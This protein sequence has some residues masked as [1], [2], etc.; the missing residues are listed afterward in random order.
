MEKLNPNSSN[1]IIGVLYHHSKGNDISPF[2]NYVENIKTTTRENKQVVIMEDLNFDLLN[3]ENHLNTN[4]FLE[5]MLSNFLQ[6]FIIQPTKTS[7]NLC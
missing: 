3:S 4:A 1:K 2:I 5:T 7:K 6:L